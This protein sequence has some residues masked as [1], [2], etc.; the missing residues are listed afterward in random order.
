MSP[1]PPGKRWP[2][3]GVASGCRDTLSL[4]LGAFWEAG[5]Q[6]RK[7]R[8]WDVPAGGQQPCAVRGKKWERDLFIWTEK[9]HQPRGGLPGEGYLSPRGFRRL[10]C[11]LMTTV[12]MA[13]ETLTGCCQAP[14]RL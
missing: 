14:A 8:A 4:D 1:P 7:V 5:K 6:E 12:T 9:D 11:E 10:I 2:G 3:P 13:L